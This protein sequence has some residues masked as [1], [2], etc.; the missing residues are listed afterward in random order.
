MEEILG[1]A[2]IYSWIHGSMIVKSKIQG[3]TKYENSVLV[4]ALAAF[5]LFV[6]GTVAV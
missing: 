5:I 6:I 1:I 3:T 4:F 2:M